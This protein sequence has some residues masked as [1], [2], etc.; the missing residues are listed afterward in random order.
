M[1]KPTLAV[2]NFSVEH[3]IRGEHIEHDGLDVLTL[4]RVDALL[5]TAAHGAKER[6]WRWF[7]ALDAVR[8]VEQLDS[9]LWPVVARRAEETGTST[10]IDLCLGVAAASGARMPSGIAA[11]ARMAEVA[12]SWL[13]FASNAASVE[14]GNSAAWERRKARWM[15]ADSPVSAADGFARATAR[16]IADRRAPGASQHKRAADR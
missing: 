7:W 13:A 5:A 14:W 6:W 3:C 8:Q 16:L 12:K 4:D 2:S 9:S 1:K 11:S 10:A 15:I